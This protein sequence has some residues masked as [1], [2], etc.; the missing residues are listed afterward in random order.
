MASKYDALADHLRRQSGPRHIMSSAQIERLIGTPLPASSRTWSAWWGNDRSPDSRHSQ[1]KHGWLAAGWEVESLDPIRQTVT[2]RRQ[3][4]SED[5]ST[6]FGSS[7]RQ[8][9]RYPT[10]EPVSEGADR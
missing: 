6:G 9:S 7:G 4:I 1:S 3:A 5:G 10:E 8:A 2:F